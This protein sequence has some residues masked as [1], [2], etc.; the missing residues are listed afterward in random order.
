[1]QK[2]KDRNE[3]IAERKER[4]E[5]KAKELEQWEEIHNLDHGDREDG[6]EHSSEAV[7]KET[8]VFED[9][10]TKEMFGGE[11]SVVIKYGMPGD[12]DDDEN[13]D[14]DDAGALRDAGD[15][16]DRDL[17]ASRQKGQ[18]KKDE[19]Q[20]F[21]G[22]VGKYMKELEGNLP[23]KSKSNGKRWSGKG[24]HGASNMKGLSSS[25][26]K[27]SGKLLSKFTAK[28][29]PATGKREK[30]KRVKLGGKKNVGKKNKKGQI[31]SK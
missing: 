17:L 18:K 29:G 31:G 13:G 15:D 12:D 16:D 10:E 9:D 8:R 1:M 30:E 21:A 11:V 26:S 2:L 14:D 20:F 25:K 5:E 19:E 4:R 28:G 3:K 7:E 24:I 6:G 27:A 22:N 23:A